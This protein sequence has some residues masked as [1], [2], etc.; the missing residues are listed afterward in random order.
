M[1]PTAAT[2]RLWW[3]S[4]QCTQSKSN[5]TTVSNSKQR[6][7]LKKFS[8]SLTSKII[9]WTPEFTSIDCRH[10]RLALGALWSVKS[11]LFCYCMLLLVPLTCANI[12]ISDETASRPISVLHAMS[13]KWSGKRTGQV[14]N[15]ALCQK[16][17]NIP[18]NV[19]SSVV[20]NADPSV[21]TGSLQL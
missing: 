4:P 7:K 11:E 18:L 21:R 20:M 13:W 15:E 6:H 19:V 1:A 9:L 5:M 10:I 14:E 16:F 17:V 3:N 2:A 12:S 8:C